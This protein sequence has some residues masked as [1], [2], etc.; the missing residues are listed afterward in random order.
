MERSVDC[1]NL[2]YSRLQ[3]CSQPLWSHWSIFDRMQECPQQPANRSRRWVYAMLALAL[4]DGA[5]LVSFRIDPHYPEINRLVS[6]VTPSGPYYR[7]PDIS[8]LRALARLGPKAYPALARLLQ[9]HDTKLDALYDRWCTRL[10]DF[11]WR[12]RDWP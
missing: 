12:Q 1:L 7:E 11:L 3:S 8:N 9:A 2:C 5:L 4:V 10:P 6:Q